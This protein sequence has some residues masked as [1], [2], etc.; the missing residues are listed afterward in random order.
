MSSATAEACTDTLLLNRV[1]WF[2][3]PCHLTSD[4]GAQFTSALWDCT[5][6]TLGAQLH[7]NS[8]YHP[9]SNGE[10]E[11]LHGSLKVSL[12]TCL[13]SPSWTEQLP[14]A[15]PS[16]RL[17]VWKDFGCSAVDLVFWH[18]PMLPRELFHH[19]T[20]H[21]PSTT[22]TYHHTATSLPSPMTLPLDSSPYVYLC[23][24]CH[25]MSLQH[26]YSGPFPVLCWFSKSFEIAM[27]GS[28]SGSA[29]T[30]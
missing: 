3:V 2:G 4:R 25:R 14:W 5:A 27:S 9:Q 11:R 20:P 8:S 1:A 6:T 18:S 26:P 7:C 19:Q 17:A 29:W 22:P 15:L 23:R 10:V 21:L 13:T 24:D 28:P 12:C 16:I 30:D